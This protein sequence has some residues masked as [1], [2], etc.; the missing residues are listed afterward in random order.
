[1]KV[2]ETYI[3]TFSDKESEEFKRY[4]DV[5]GRSS[6][7]L[8]IKLYDIIRKSD[9]DE[10]TDVVRKLYNLKSS[11]VITSATKNT[12]YQW[13]SILTQ[14]VET[15]CT[16]KV[17]EKEVSL[18][19]FKQYV[20]AQYLFSKKKYKAGFKY[21]QKAEE[22]A[23]ESEDFTLL[24]KILELQLD[25]AWTM[26]Q[27]NLDLTIQKLEA[28]DERV[29]QD[30]KIT[31]AF[32]VLQFKL[33][34]AKKN[35]IYLE[36][37]ELLAEAKKAFGSMELI[38]QHANSFY[39]FTMAIHT[40]FYE[41]NEFKKCLKHL[42]SAFNFME[43]KQIF[44]KH[45]MSMQIDMI[46]KILRCSINAIDFETAQKF[47]KKLSKIGEDNPSDHS[48]NFNCVTYEYVL[49][50][51]NGDLE[52]GV[53]TINGLNNSPLTQELIKEDDN[54][55]HVLM[56]NMISSSI[57]SKDYSK[58]KKYLFL[59][60]NKEKRLK[61]Y[62]GMASVMFLYLVELMIYFFQND[63]YTV[64][65]R[66]PVI[67]KRFKSYLDISGVSKYMEM[68]DLFRDMCKYESGNYPE[69]LV[70]KIKEFLI[71]KNKQLLG[72][73]EFLPIEPFMMSQI[74]KTDLEHELILFLRR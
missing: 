41:K 45:N 44:G 61:R 48:I 66:I 68:L 10:S 19:V 54:S 43:E 42:I 7:R 29:R 9:T 47:H 55:F 12:Y 65:K 6:D 51:C 24:A 25:Y 38:R 30:A 3:S 74:N 71:T 37:D 69:S 50:I 73:T 53:E 26:T 39:K 20:L 72:I 32:N 17:A 1:M 46:T 62:S 52:K 36:L 14:H 2:L 60:V 13:R 64:E 67:K 28:N 8:D 70:D 16:Q 58:A 15:F 40:V 23:F 34:Q 49:H 56:N 35:G 4:L 57:L 18:V 31:R 11:E 22:L 5:R 27:F 59:K 63:E 33:A 21:L